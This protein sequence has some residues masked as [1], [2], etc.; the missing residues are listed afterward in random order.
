MAGVLKVLL[1]FFFSPRQCGMLCLLEIFQLL[2]SG[3]GWGGWDGKYVPVLVSSACQPLPGLLAG[4]AH[5]PP[6]ARTSPD[7]EGIANGPPRLCLAAAG[8]EGMPSTPKPAPLGRPCTPRPVCFCSR[9]LAGVSQKSLPRPDPVLP[10]PRESLVLFRV[11][12]TDSKIR[13]WLR[14]LMVRLET[15]ATICC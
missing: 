12:Q 1:G 2:W 11:V 6:H 14:R 15:E 3:E 8:R 13:R 7:I 9:W 5:T 4:T 10:S